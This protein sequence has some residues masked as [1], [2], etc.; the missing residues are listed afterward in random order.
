LAVLS[1]VALESFDG[2]PFRNFYRIFGVKSLSNPR[3][4]VHRWVSKQ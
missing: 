1:V 4:K 2:L 3:K